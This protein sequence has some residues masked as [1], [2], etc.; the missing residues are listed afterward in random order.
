MKLYGESMFSL[1]IL[2]ILTAVVAAAIFILINVLCYK[3]IRKRLAEDYGEKPKV[4][5]EFG[6]Q[7]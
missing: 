7:K 1:G 4:K 2:I 5:G 3:R 6:C